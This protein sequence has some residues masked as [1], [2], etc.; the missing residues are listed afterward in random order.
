LQFISQYAIVI[1]VKAVHISPD[2][3][4]GLRRHRKDAKRILAKIDRYA[5]TGAGDVTRLVSSSTSRL[6]VGNY[7]VVFEETQTDIFVTKIGPRGSI[8]D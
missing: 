4:L 5:E 2:A 3:A 7:R 1:I 8:Y 6:R